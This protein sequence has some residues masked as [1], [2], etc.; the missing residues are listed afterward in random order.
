MVEHDLPIAVREV[1]ERTA[2]PALDYIGFSM[3]GMLLYA[4]LG[5]TIAA[6]RVRRV[7]II[8]S[9]GIIRPPL[10]VPVPALVGRVP[11]FLF[12]TLRFRLAARAGAFASEWVRTPAHRWVINPKNLAPGTARHALMNVIEDIPGPLNRDF[13]VFAATAGGALTHEGV[14]VLDRLARFSSPAAPT[15]WPR[16]ARCAPLSTLGAPRPSSRTSAS[17][18]SRITA[19]AIWRSGSASE[20]KFSSHLRTFSSET[21]AENEKAVARVRARARARRSTRPRRRSVAL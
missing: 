6:E 5:H 17:S 13:A 11:A 3:G 19:T 18:C 2:R 14:K 10:P 21:P 15:A 9:P 20:T 4:A 16:R 7:A 12:P 1:L 8:G